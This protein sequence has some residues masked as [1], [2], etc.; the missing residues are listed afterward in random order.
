VF[1]V[2]RIRVAECCAGSVPTSQTVP[3]VGYNALTHIMLK[4][5]E[6]WNMSWIVP[7]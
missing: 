6:K 4:V 3:E 7:R 2:P 5:V 1:S